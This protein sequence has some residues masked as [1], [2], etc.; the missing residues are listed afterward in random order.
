MTKC[1]DPQVGATGV[2][3]PRLTPTAFCPAD[4][5]LVGQVLDAC[6]RLYAELSGL[7]PRGAAAGG[8]MVS[9]SRLPPLPLRLEVL[10]LQEDLSVTLG[11]LSARVRRSVLP[12]RRP[13][14]AVAMDARYLRT[15]L[16]A[17]LALDEGETGAEAG[18]FLIDWQMR[19]RKT[20]GTHTTFER[21]QAPCPT[22]DIKALVRQYGSETAECR[23]CFTRISEVQYKQWT[24]LLMCGTV[25]SAPERKAR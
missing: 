3:S 24:A 11:D 8:D 9:G 5:H 25:Q 14:V 23:S 20:M 22:C 16:S 15:H 2:Y 19:V 10:T 13:A 21:L 12:S 4:T 17:L 7:L 6:P 1:S 18:L